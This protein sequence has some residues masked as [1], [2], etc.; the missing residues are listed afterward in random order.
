MY[1]LSHKYS[2]VASY[3]SSPVA[4]H[5][6]GNDRSIALTPIQITDQTVFSARRIIFV[7]KCIFSFPNDDLDIF[8][9]WIA[10]QHVRNNM[11]ATTSTHLV[12]KLSL[13]LGN[14][15]LKKRLPLISFELFPQN[16]IVI[17]KVSYERIH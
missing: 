3:G 10:Y 11:Y 13:V 12:Y 9:S 2:L 15:N 16:P 14:E 6:F 1:T 7:L 8:I 5:F 4:D 17:R